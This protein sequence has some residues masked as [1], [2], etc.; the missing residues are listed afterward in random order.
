MGVS[1]N[2]FIPVV[3][4]IKENFFK[5]IKITKI[6]NVLKLINQEIGNTLMHLNSLK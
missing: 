5:L 1:L 3:G 2:N 6:E 4:V